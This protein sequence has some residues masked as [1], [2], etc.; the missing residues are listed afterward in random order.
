MHIDSTHGTVSLAVAR[1]R[2]LTHCTLCTV[3]ISRYRVVAS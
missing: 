1:R 3:D 2:Y